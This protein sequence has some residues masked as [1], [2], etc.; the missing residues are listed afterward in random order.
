MDGVIWF[1][2]GSQQTCLKEESF[3]DSLWEPLII[4][5]FES[6]GTMTKV[7]W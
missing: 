3:C 5:G 2:W 7:S 4:N 1:L 6:V